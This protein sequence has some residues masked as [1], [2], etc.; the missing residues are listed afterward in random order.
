MKQR[1]LSIWLRGV[2]ALIAAAVLFLAAVFAPALGAEAVRQSPS[3]AGYYWPCLIFLWCTALPVFAALAIAWRIFAEIGRDNSF[4]EKNARRLRTISL[5]ALVDT[6]LYIAGVV[7]L[8][9]LRVL[10][11]GVFTGLMCI[12]FMGLAMTVGTAALSHLAKKAADL[13]VE[14]D[15]V[16]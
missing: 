10:H 7:A 14:N 1:E 3:M 15:L 5:L 16:I 9:V 12:V 11:P 13:K 2:V 4:C 6:L 8:G